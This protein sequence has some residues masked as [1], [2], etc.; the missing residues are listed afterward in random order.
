MLEM[1]F[2]MADQDAFG[3]LGERPSLESLPTFEQK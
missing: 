1:A 3:V 2:W